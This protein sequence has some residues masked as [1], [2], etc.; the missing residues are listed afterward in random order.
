MESHGRT[1]SQ[2]RVDE[3][4]EKGGEQDVAV[5]AGLM[6]ADW[7]SRATHGDSAGKVGVNWHRGRH[8]HVLIYWRGVNTRGYGLWLSE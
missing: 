5:E 6:T 3:H 4:R 8:V 1:G 7:T 2:S